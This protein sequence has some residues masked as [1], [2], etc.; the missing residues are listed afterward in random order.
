MVKKHP[1]ISEEQIP[2]GPLQPEKRG[3]EILFAE[4]LELMM[5]PGDNVEAIVDLALQIIE[6]PKGGY[7]QEAE[8]LLEAMD[9]DGKVQMKIL[10]R[11]TLE[12]E[13]DSSEEVGIEKAKRNRSVDRIL[14]QARAFIDSPLLDERDRV[15]GLCAEVLQREAEN[16]EALELLERLGI[17]AAELEIEEEE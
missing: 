8:E 13:E 14:E 17:D 12:L 16:E 9:P 5:T 3:N 15:A 11:V 6:A 10:K 2:V 1:E 7:V 4:A